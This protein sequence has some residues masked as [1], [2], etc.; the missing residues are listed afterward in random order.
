MKW[1]T[2]DYI[3]THSRIDFD[4]EDA[5]LELY[6]NAAE[7]MILTYCRR[8]EEDFYEKYG[9]IPAA[10]YI[11]ALELVETSYTHR[12]PVSMQNLS[13]VAYSFDFHIKPYMRLS[14]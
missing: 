5:L 11:A 2:I 3:K 7:E 6:A 9:G 13:A 12:S 4:C 1:L 10:L 14:K 8:T